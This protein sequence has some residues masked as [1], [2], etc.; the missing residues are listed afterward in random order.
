MVFNSESRFVSMD[1]LGRTYI[2]HLPGKRRGAGEYYIVQ[3]GELG[4][5]VMVKSAVYVRSGHEIVAC[6]GKAYVI[7]GT[8]RTEIID[9]NTGEDVTE[10]DSML[11]AVHDFVTAV[12]EHYIFVFGGRSKKGCIS[13]TIQCFDT[14]KRTWSTVGKLD[15][16]VTKDNYAAVTL[17]DEIHLIGD[18]NLCFSPTTR[19]RQ[20]RSFFHVPALDGG[21]ITAAV[22]ETENMGGSDH[23]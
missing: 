2:L 16:S 22:I 4:A 1:D 6:A 23:Q 7:G 10:T 9:L 21:C 12:W 5:F 15:M 8:H 13:S 19:Q 11:L 14:Q 17:M 3:R 20:N 18:R